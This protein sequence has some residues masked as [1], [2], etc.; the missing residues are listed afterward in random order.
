MAWHAALRLHY[1][2][3]DER[4]RAQAEHEGPLR[5]LKALYPEGPGI[6]HHVLVHP[7]SGLVGG[8]VLGL[9]MTLA[10]NAHALATTAGATRFYRSLGL[11]AQ[12]SV[13]A[14][15]A[16]GARLEW[17]P[18]ENIIY[19]GAQAVNRQCFELDAGAE[20]LGWDLLALGLPAADRP[21][22]RGCVHQ[23]IEVPGAWLDAARID[24]ADVR[25]LDSPLGLA[26]RRALATMWFAAG[27]P[28]ALSRVELAL[29]AAR[30]VIA[31]HGAA[32]RAGVSLV[33][34]QVLV[35]RALAPRIEP[36][37]ALLQPVRVAWREVLW[38][39]R[40]A[41]PRVWQT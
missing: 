4:T 21:F 33:H 34:P 39:L 6:C 35:L 9:T 38:Q 27:S 10:A 13:Q 26:G 28:L 17:L 22:V 31:Q 7:P 23:R 20:M 5:V 18:Q 3:A 14:H 41:A 16:S 32:V 1:E 12:Q 25:L 40:G 37:A 15:L 11:Q 8:D 30:Q 2:R 36:L 24:A 19:S 29:E